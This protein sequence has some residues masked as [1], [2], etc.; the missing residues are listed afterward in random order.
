[1]KEGDKI[2]VKGTVTEIRANGDVILKLAD[3]EIV[4]VS[5][6]CIVECQK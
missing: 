2:F 4:I 5:K 3:G 6:E 1:M